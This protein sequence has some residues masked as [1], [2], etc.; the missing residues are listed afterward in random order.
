MKLACHEAGC[1]TDWLLLDDVLLTWTGSVSN[2][3]AFY[4]TGFRVSG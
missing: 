3:I 1:G 4:L 2:F